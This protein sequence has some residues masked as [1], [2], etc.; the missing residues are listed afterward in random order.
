MAINKVV[1]GQQTLIDLTQD[2]VTSASHILSGHTGHLADGSQVAGTAPNNASITYSMSGGAYATSTPAKTVLGEGFTSKIKVPTGYALSGIT[3]TMNGVD[4][5][6]SVVEYEEMSD[7][8]QISLQSKSVEYTPTTSAQSATVTA[9]SGYDG[10][11]SVAVSVGAIPSE[12]VI[13]SGTLSVTE[14]GTKDVTNYA[15]VSVNVPTSGGGSNIE[16]GITNTPIPN[17][18]NMFYALENGTATTGEFTPA[19]SIPNTS[20][21]I[22]DTGLS[23]VNGLFI[24]DESQATRNTDN[25][26]ENTLWAIVF[27]PGSSTE[28]YAMTRL[29]IQM[30]YGTNTS[31]INRG[32]L[33]RVSAWE[34]TNGKLYAT[35]SYNRNKNY[36]PFYPGHTYRWVAW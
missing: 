15:S 1:Y 20:T 11:S 35:G 25:T 5:T 31:G 10:L 26:P 14:N 22:L 34:V 29:N 28:S 30:G 27:N 32:F 36:T 21:L 6:S 33:N 9:D 13:P 4:I 12:Y 2:T 16:I 19:Q 8:G 7:S 18:L 3:V 24:A 17:I 23:T